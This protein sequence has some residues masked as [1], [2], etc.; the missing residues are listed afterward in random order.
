MEE[1]I[2]QDKTLSE[3]DIF[4]KLFKFKVSDISKQKVW[5]ELLYVVVTMAIVLLVLKS[6]TYNKFTIE[7]RNTITKEL[8]FPYLLM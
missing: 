8:C 3:L 2:K 1:I 6:Y 5:F 4:Q 7:V